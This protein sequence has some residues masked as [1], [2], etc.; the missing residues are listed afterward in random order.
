MSDEL[1]FS[2]CVEAIESSYEFML[3]YAAQGRDKEGESGDGPSIRVF[4]TSLSEALGA[5]DGALKAEITMGPRDNSAQLEKFSTVLGDDASR[6]RA[7]VD[8]ALSVPS[9]TS[10]L[11]DNL[12]ASIHLRALLTSLFLMD[13]AVQAR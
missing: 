3:A 10:Q 13:E 5:I 12:N 2:S 1:D 6:A 11:V 4:L 8:L 9:I 7:A